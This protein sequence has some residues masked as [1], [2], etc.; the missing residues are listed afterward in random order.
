MMEKE[1]LVIDNY[2]SF[3]YNLVEYVRKC[4]FKV[5]VFRND[6]IPLQQIETYNTI[7]LSPGPGVPQEAGLLKKIIEEYGEKKKILGVCL[8]M[9]AIAEVYGCELE[10]MSQVF[11]GVATPI[12]I[13]KEDDL[14]NDLP[15]HF[16]VGRYHSW[17]VSKMNFSKN[18]EITSMDNNGIIMSIKHKYYKVHGVQ[19]HPES[20]LTEHGMKIIKN[21][22][23]D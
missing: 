12:S 3:T 6:E 20:I 5:D 2:D 1:V 17:S 7:I 15:I 21:F 18:L 22:L 14:Y 11:H 8:G 10:N 23:R 19:Y 9:Q 13:I 4:G 16:H